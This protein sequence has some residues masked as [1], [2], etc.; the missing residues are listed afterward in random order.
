[1]SHP[2]HHAHLGPA[3]GPIPPAS[4]QQPAFQHPPHFG[5]QPYLYPGVLPVQ[6]IA[7]QYHA[8]GLDM[9]V[10][11]YSQQYGAAP[12][13]WG[14]GQNMAGGLL[15]PGGFPPAGGFPNHDGFPNPGAPNT[16]VAGLLNPVPQPIVGELDT[17]G[18]A[19]P[20]VARVAKRIERG[21]P[22]AA[23]AKR[24]YPNKQVR[25]GGMS[26]LAKDEPTADL[27]PQ[28]FYLM[29]QSLKPMLRRYLLPK[30][31]RTGQTSETVHVPGW[32]PLA[33]L[34]SGIELARNHANG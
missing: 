16:N 4:T 27:L 15:I 8:G 2:H 22:A 3:P 25:E 10:P 6:G 21:A 18:N 14:Y 17:H 31:M 20:T 12:Q 28:S 34:V 9:N 11:P 1:M 19:Q 32:T 30:Q 7:N 13:L 33:T 26:H 5:F 29:F 24:S 23:P